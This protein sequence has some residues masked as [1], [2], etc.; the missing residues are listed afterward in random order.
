MT[1]FD[2]FWPILTYFD[3]FWSFWALFEMFE[4]FGVRGGRVSCRCIELIVA[5]Q[6]GSEISK[7]VVKITFFRHFRRK[8]RTQKTLAKRRHFKYS[9][10][11]GFW[12]KSISRNRGQKSAFFR[13]FVGLLG[14]SAK[15][16]APGGRNSSWAVGRQFTN[17]RLYAQSFFQ[18]GSILGGVQIQA[19]W[20][21]EKGG[22][23][24]RSILG[25]SCL[26]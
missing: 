19:F 16:D 21:F 12:K 4:I 10:F 20:W 5:A 25:N 17:R 26:V 9:R 3:L 8:W 14:G 1:L 6:R 18:L 22:S 7:K 2:L 13:V 23:K 11:F 24:F 15:N